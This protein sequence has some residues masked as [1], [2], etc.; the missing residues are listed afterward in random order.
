[1]NSIRI[2]FNGIEQNLDDFN[3]TQSISF[4]FRKQTTT[5][6][7]GKSF[8][9]EFDVRGDAFSYLYSN[10]ITQPVPGLTSVAVTVFDTCCRNDDGSDRLLFTGEIKGSDVRWCE[11]ESGIESCS[12]TFTIIDNSADADA[13]TCLK[14]LF[15]WD[16]KDK[17]DGTGLSDGIRSGR[18]PVLLTYCVDI[19]PGFLQEIILIFGFLSI[20]VLYPVALTVGLL[21][22]IVNFLLFIFSFGQFGTLSELNYLDD[23]IAFV[24]RLQSIIIG[25]GR[26]HVGVYVYSYLTNMCDICGIGLNSSIFDFGGDYHD[27]VRTDAAFRPGSRASGIIPFNTFLSNRPNINGVQFLDSFKQFNI[28]WRVS[29]GVLYVERKDFEFGGLWFDESTLPVNSVIEK[30]FEPLDES[31]FAFAE[32][33]Y[34]KDAVDNTGDEVNPDWTQESID[35]NVPVNPVQSGLFSRTF[36]FSTAQF[37]N[38]SGRDDVSAL[39][40]QLYKTFFPALNNFKGVMLIENGVFSF[41]RLLQIDPNSD[42]LDAR[43]L[44]YDSALGSDLFDYNIDWW[45]KESYTDGNGVSRDTLYPR[46][47]FL[48]DPRTTGIK[49]RNYSITVNADCDLIR[50][51]NVDSFIRISQ[52]GIVFEASVEN[53]DYNLTQNTITVT[54]KI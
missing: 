24:S 28:D 42:P 30:C 25:C 9:P 33:S 15:P 51:I 45:V 5:G 34:A 31:P 44:R 47:L 36:T 18:D 8:A 53:I 29:D 4:S 49:T 27:T 19:R 35:W 26:K 32:Y 7:S 11:T 54:G 14:N 22:T 13:L 20:F 43:V 23:A 12:M 48:D 46:F 6:E 39:D 2:Y 38:D 10:L 41:P 40:K 17:F 37:R 21:I 50:G 16:R 1:M 3:G 52:G